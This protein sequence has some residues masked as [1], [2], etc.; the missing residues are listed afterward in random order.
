MAALTEFTGIGRVE[1]TDFGLAWLTGLHEAVRIRRHL[2]CHG[3]G[4][5]CHVTQ[6]HFI[7]KLAGEFREALRCFWGQCGKNV[8]KGAGKFAGIG[9]A[10]KIRSLPEVVPDVGVW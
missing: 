10:H 7:I 6:G 4:Q 5:W 9:G 1:Q 2:R 3:G 8:F